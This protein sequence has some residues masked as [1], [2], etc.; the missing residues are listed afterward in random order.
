MNHAKDPLLGLSVLLA[1]LGALQASQG[2][3]TQ[4][5]EKYPTTF[6]ISMTVISCAVAGLT[7][8]R[9]VIAARIASE[10]E[11]SKLF[12]AARDHSG[13]DDVA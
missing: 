2:L 4:L 3:L 1:I 6:G 11:A 13:V 9:N 12:H 8:Y 10:S 5:I 7:V